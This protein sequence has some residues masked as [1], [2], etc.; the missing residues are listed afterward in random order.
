MTTP[1]Q[2]RRLPVA[3]GP[4]S[5]AV[6]QET[7]NRQARQL[8]EPMQILKRVG[9]GLGSDAV[10]KSPQPQFGPG[11]VAQRLAPL[12]AGLERG[13]HD[14]LGVVLRHEA[15]HVGVGNFGD[16]L[17]QLADTVAVHLHA[18]ADLGF[19]LVAFGHGH[20]PHV[21]AQPGDL[22]TSHLAQAHGRPHPGGDAILD[23]FVLPMPDDDLPRLAQAGADES[24]LAVAVGG[25]V[26]VHEIHVDRR[27]RQIT[28]ELGMQ[29]GQR[30]DEGRQ[31]GD[32]HLGRRERVHPGDHADA[33]RRGIGV[34][35]DT[36]DRLGGRDDRLEHDAAGQSRGAIESL[37]QAAAVVGHLA[38]GRLAVEML[39]AGEKPDFRGFQIHGMRL[40]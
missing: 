6:G 22:Q 11:R 34:A 25:L 23:L 32:P 1:H 24:E 21:V 27:P 35:A 20:L 7:L 9:K 17:D 36:E 18:E 2:R 38:K 30:L 37:D 16:G 13:G 15:V 12:A 19:D 28:M 29:V 33:I 39:A 8:I 26:Q 5:I 3:L 10:E 31:S 14:I 40:A 4:E